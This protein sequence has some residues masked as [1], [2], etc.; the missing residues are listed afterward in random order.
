MLGLTW[1][2]LIHTVEDRRAAEMADL[3]RYYDASADRIAEEWYGNEIL[4]PTHRDFMTLLPSDPRILDF[5]CGPGYEAM[6]LHALGADVVG[7]DMSSKSIEIA[8][9]NNPECNFMKM[10]FYAIDHRIGRFDGV[11]AS[12]SLIHV[13]PDRM[14]GVLASIRNLLLPEGAL[15]ALIR[16]GNGPIVRQPVVDGRAMEWIAYRYTGDEL[17]RYCRDC[18]LHFIRM[19]SLDVVLAAAGW[20]CYFYQADAL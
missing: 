18:H 1:T 5:G 4:M 2:F 6:R 10:D 16:D 17:N 7:I 3:E 15:A 12:G 20:R 9:R 19:G 11:L 13:P 8:R 14:P